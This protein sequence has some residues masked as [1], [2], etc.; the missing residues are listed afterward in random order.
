MASPLTTPGVT[1]KPSRAP[2][3]AA[4]LKGDDQSEGTATEGE[5]ER[6]V[7]KTLEMA[8]QEGGKNFSQGQRQLLALARGILK[9]RTSSI[10]ILDESTASL[11]ESYLIPSSVP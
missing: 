10:L 11:G 8:V 5:S 4:S 9:L 7:V 2:S 3:R 6:Y 1:P